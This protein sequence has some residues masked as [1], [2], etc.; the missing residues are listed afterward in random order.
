MVLTGV[1]NFCVLEKLKKSQHFLTNFPSRKEIDI[2]IGAISAS[3]SSKESRESHTTKRN[4]LW[5]LSSKYC[6]ICLT[7]FFYSNG[8]RK[9]QHCTFS[10]GL[11]ICQPTFTYTIKLLYLAAQSNFSISCSNEIVFTNSFSFIVIFE[12]H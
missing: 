12:L 10:T 9:S 6:Q 4:T 8:V 5:R 3:C 7:T 1:V 11:M 2:N